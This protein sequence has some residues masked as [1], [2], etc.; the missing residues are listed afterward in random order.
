MVAGPIRSEGSAGRTGE[1]EA[2]TFLDQ[3]VS[4][5]SKPATSQRVGSGFAPIM[6]PGE[7]RI[8]NVELARQAE[9]NKVRVRPFDRKDRFYA[10][11]VRTKK[12]KARKLARAGMGRGKGRKGAPQKKSRQPRK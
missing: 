9:Q 5:N 6:R 11:R 10:W 12:V 8:A 1:V 4:E 7:Y 3:H 2:K